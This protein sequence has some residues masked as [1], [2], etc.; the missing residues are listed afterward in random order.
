MSLF[1][2]FRAILA[3]VPNRPASD[4]SKRVAVELKN[5]RNRHGFLWK[6]IEAQTGIAH[7]TLSRMLN[8]ETDIPVSRLM[9][10][11]AAAGISAAG[12]IDEATRHMPDGYLQDLLTPDVTYPAVSSAS[13]TV[14]PIHETDWESHPGQKA[15]LNDD[16]GDD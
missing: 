12:I 6:D 15:A 14:P 2:D 10:I 5:A 7:A 3:G 8:G 1:W 9:L 4:L 16:A 11:C 13:A